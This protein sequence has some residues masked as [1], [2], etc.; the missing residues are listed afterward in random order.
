MCKKISLCKKDTITGR[1]EIL[2][3]ILGVNVILSAILEF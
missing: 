1:A 3:Q 2:S